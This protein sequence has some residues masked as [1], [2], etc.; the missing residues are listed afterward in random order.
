M[1]CE[2]GRFSARTSTMA[3]AVPKAHHAAK[4]C[5]SVP[6]SFGVAGLVE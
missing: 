5:I 4:D 1:H 2:T 6:R 3:S